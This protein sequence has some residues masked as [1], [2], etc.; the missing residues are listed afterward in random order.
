MDKEEAVQAALQLLQQAGI[1]ASIV[2]IYGSTTE[3][4]I[5]LPEVRLALRHG[6]H[7][8]L[9]NRKPQLSVVLDQ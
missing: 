9:E 2:R 4:V 1:H 6:A 8:P 7:V 5:V 3:A